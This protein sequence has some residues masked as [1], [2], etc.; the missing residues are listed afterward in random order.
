M[1]TQTK[2]TKINFVRFFLI[3]FGFLSLEYAKTNV[4]IKKKRKTREGRVMVTGCPYAS[5]ALE[6]KQCQLLDRILAK[7]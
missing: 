5:R 1:Y 2:N 7:F 6:R 3:F 4:D